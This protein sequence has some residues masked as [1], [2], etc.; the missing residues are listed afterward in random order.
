[1]DGRIS[2]WGC[3][4]SPPASDLALV[5]TVPS[6]ILERVTNEIFI[7]VIKV[8]VDI[9]SG[10]V[11]ASK[12][13]SVKRSLLLFGLLWGPKLLSVVVC[14]GAHAVEWMRVGPTP[15]SRVGG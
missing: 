5:T 1:M 7:Y 9:T 11:L 4:L 15:T 3:A 2:I 8:R 12:V 14:W 13:V 6:I 10:I